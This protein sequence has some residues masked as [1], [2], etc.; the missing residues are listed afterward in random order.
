MNRNWGEGPL[1]G[2]AIIRASNIDDIWGTAPIRLGAALW[3][4]IDHQRGYHPDPFWGGLLD[5]ARVPRYSYYLFQSQY[6][7]DLKIPGI[8]TGPMVKIANELTQVSPR[9]RR[10]L[11]QLRAG[12]AD[13]AGARSSAR[14]RPTRSIT[15]SRTPPFT[16]KGVFD[17]GEIKSH[18]RDKTGQIEM[19]AEGLIGGQVVA[20]EVKRYAERTTGLALSVDDQGVGLSADGADFVPLRATVID[21]K[22]VPKVLAEEYVYFQVD[23]PGEIVG[24]PGTETNPAHTE[25]GTATALL[26]AGLRPGLIKVTA[27]ARGLAPAEVYVRSGAPALP[28]AY[29]HDYAAASKPA[30]NGAVLTPQTGG[31][32]SDNDTAKLKEQ[33]HELQLELTS[34]QQELMELHS[35]LGK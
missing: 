4:G 12:A 26:R 19:V 14:R 10:R 18:W 35:K 20:R 16:F 17:F 24:G 28:L 32:A 11:Q 1:L 8:K 9:R 2:Q 27:Y 3:A 15:T 13:M 34:K 6:A 30:D 25:F 5:G 7:P 22:G 31:G 23:G 21:N 29:D 33:V